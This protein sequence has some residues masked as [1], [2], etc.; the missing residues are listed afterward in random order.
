MRRVGVWFVVAWCNYRLLQW[1]GLVGYGILRFGF[2][3]LRLVVCDVVLGCG[4]WF[5]WFL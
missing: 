1:L 5:C 2:G 4:G 3:V